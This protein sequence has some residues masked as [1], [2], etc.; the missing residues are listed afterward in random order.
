VLEVVAENCWRTGTLVIEISFDE[1]SV[2]VTISYYGK[3][4]EFPTH[5]P[6]ED[7]ILGSDDGVRRLAGYMLR[8]AADRM[9]SELRYGRPFL[10]FHF[11]H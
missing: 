11:D 10:T 9:R 3:L 1:F 4:L 5:R 8:H 7:E 6:D 2:D